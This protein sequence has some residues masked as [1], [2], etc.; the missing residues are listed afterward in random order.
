MA[1]TRST[2][3]RP[4]ASKFPGRCTLCSKPFDTGAQIRWDSATRKSQHVTC[5]SEDRYPVT[6]IANGDELRERLAKL[7]DHIASLTLVFNDR[8]AELLPPE[9]AEPC[10]FCKGTGKVEHR[11]NVSDTLDYSDW[12]TYPVP[13]GS[14]FELRWP[15]PYDRYAGPSCTVNGEVAQWNRETCCYE[16]ATVKLN[17][18]C[19]DAAKVRWGWEYAR[20]KAIEQTHT[21]FPQMRLAYDL[22][23]WCLAD[24]QIVRGDVATVI[25][26][27]KPRTGKV[28]FVGESD[29]SA[30]IRVQVQDD[31][32]KRYGGAVETATLVTGSRT[33]CP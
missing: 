6:L 25:N 33:Y 5:P 3:T 20:R 12:Q 16:T 7:E 11:R 21:E 18:R 4:F 31:E 30:G 15:E 9:P 13:C 24:L 14:V 32:G 17:T 19:V 28:T 23:R 27:N 26:R 10:E 22:K 2:L 8:V 1:R 29:Y